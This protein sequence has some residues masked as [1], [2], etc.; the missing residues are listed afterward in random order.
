MKLILLGPPGAGK[1]TQAEALTEKLG[2]P[3]ISTGNILREAVKNETPVGLKVKA[4]MDGGDL[5]PDDVVISVVIDR[6]SMADCEKGFILDG[7]PRTVAQAQAIDAQGIEV[8]TVLLI[9][10]T[11]EQVIERLGGRRSC[12]DCGTV[13][14]IQSK[15]SAKEGICDHC[16]AEL[17][18]RKDDEHAT[19]LHRLGTYHNETTPLI[20]Y[21]REQGKLKTVDSLSTVADTT[22][23]VFKALGLQ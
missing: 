11:D 6:I 4:I 21:Y 14:H 18:I 9:D 7:V 1:G 15:P 2:V 16:G 17:V 19:I 23:A 8:D 5:V 20:E 3:T 13:Y 22:V 10:N 12:P